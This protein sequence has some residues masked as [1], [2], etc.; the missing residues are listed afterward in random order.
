MPA[1]GKWRERFGKDRLGGLGGCPRPGQPRRIT[2]AMVEK[3]VTQTLESKPEHATRW[4]T[5]SMRKRP[6]HPSHLE[7]FW[8]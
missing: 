8:T 1:V 3:V 6:V 5:R 7:D 2:N 4:S